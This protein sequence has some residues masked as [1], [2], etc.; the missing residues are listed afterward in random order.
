M[1]PPGIVFIGFFADPTKSSLLPRFAVQSGEVGRVDDLLF[2][3]TRRREKCLGLAWAEQRARNRR[4]ARGRIRVEPRSGLGATF[5]FA[6][7]T[8]ENERS[9]LTMIAV[10]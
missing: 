2:S 10:V 9:Q 3:N 7:P 4:S 6:L 8:M 1:S 5:Y